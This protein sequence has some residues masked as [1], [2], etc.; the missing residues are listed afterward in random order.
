MYNHQ[1]F[2]KQ[3]DQQQALRKQ[4]DSYMTN[5]KLKEKKAGQ[6]VMNHS[7]RVMSF[8]SNVLTPLDM[9]DQ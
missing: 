4:K 5:F 6:M 1:T 3:Q 9:L 8:I 7:K 2:L